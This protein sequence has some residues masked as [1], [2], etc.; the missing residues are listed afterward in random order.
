MVTYFLFFVFGRHIIKLGVFASLMEESNSSSSSS[1]KRASY[2][3]EDK[4]QILDRLSKSSLTL[5]AFSKQEGT[6][7]SIITKWKNKEERIRK[8]SEESSVRRII[9]K[10]QRSSKYPLIEDALHRWFLFL[11]PTSIPFTDVILRGD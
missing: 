5:L 9:V 7:Q 4:L 3:I 6:N 10:K 8:R 11:K 1:R 2:T